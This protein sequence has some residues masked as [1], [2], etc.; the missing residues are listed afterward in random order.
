MASE[1]KFRNSN[2]K[3]V[4]I[5][6][7]DSNNED[8][9]VDLS[10]IAKDTDLLAGLGLKA[11]TADLK[12]IGV[13]QT[14]QHVTASRALGV[15]YTNTSGKPIIVTINLI[16]TSYDG[17]LTLTVNGLSTFINYNGNSI[18]CNIV[19]SIIVPNNVTYSASTNGGV[20]LH[21]YE[22]R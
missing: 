6:N 19:N 18:N 12:E 13:G 1:W 4:T 14:W 22:L 10:D 17:G 21:W 7:P 5:T 8:I 15:T 16:N 2:G 3:Y 11:N 9:T 20:M